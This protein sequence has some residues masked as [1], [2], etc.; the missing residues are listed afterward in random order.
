MPLQ[1]LL[2]GR[3]ELR[4]GAALQFGEEVKAVAG[5]SMITAESVLVA[6]RINYRYGDEACIAAQLIEGV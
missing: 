2:A 1:R 4:R 5:G 3:A 6:R